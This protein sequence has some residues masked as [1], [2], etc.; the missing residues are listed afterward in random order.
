MRSAADDWQ[1]CSRVRSAADALAELLEGMRS[2]EPRGLLPGDAVNPSMEALARLLPCKPPE[3]A[4]SARGCAAGSRAHGRAA[5]TARW[6]SAVV[7]TS[8]GGRGLA[9]TRL[10]TMYGSGAVRT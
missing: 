6:R 10:A 2:P 7:R 1:S 9:G 3:G 5:V 4:L 8:G